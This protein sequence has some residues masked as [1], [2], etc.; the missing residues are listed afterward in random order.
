MQFKAGQL[1]R[2]AGASVPVFRHVGHN[3]GPMTGP[4]TNTYFLGAERRCVVD[5]GPADAQQVESL[6]RCVEGP[7]DVIL[8]THTHRDHSPAARLLQ[9]ATGAQLV[10]ASVP[11]AIAQDATFVPDIEVQHGQVLELQDFSIECIATPGHVSNHF[12]YLVREEQGL[13]TGDHVLQ[14][15]TPVILPPDGDMQAYLAS[16][17][18]LLTR[19]LAFLAPGHGDI[20]RQPHAEIRQLIA[21]RQRR[22]N[23]IIEALRKSGPASIDAVVLM[24]YDDVA[25][26]LLPWAAKT[27]LAHLIKLEREGRALVRDENWELLIHE[28]N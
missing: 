28:G 8:V 10:G 18:E 9:E 11:D 13:L 27:L 1:R 2:V 14:G 6:L 4:G 20:M 26:H 24:V 16:L 7:L 15:T 25:E 3:P 12:C 5:P 21:H 22:E 19:P 17:A 23:K